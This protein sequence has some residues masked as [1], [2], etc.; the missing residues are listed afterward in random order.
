[1]DVI[2][3]KL[4][5]L[6]MS[7]LDYYLNITKIENVVG[8]WQSMTAAANVIPGIDKLG[9]F[10]LWFLNNSYTRSDNV[11]NWIKGQ[12][13]YQ[14]Y[15]AEVVSPC[16]VGKVYGIIVIKTLLKCFQKLRI[17]T[18]L[19]VW[20][21]LDIEIDLSFLEKLV[22]YIINYVCQT[23]I[24]HPAEA[25]ESFIR[26]T[27]TRE[28]YECWMKNHGCNPDIYE[29]VLQSRREQPTPHEYQFWC[30]RNNI[31]LDQENILLRQR[32]FTDGMERKMLQD[33]YWELPTIND[34]L[35]W[36]Q[37][38][39]FDTKYVEDFQLMEGFDAKFWPKFGPD[40]TALGMKE[41]YAR[42]HYAAHWINPSAGQ[43]FEMVQRLRP[44]RV[45][46]DVQFTTDDCL[47]IL[48]EQD[49]G[50]Y[51]RKRL[52]MIAY[53]TFG[54]RF[55]RQMY[56]TYELTDHEL[57]QRFQ[58]I[59][60]KPEDADILVASER[61]SRAWRRSTRTKGWSPTAI[62]W[63]VQRDL[64]TDG[65]AARLMSLLY[66]NEDEIHDLI[67]LAHL[68]GSQGIASKCRQKTLQEYEKQIEDSY[69]TGTVSR[70]DVI[71]SLTAMG[72][73]N[74][75]SQTRADTV[76]L[77]IETEFAKKHI[78]G[79]K[80]Q[81]MRGIIN[82]AGAMNALVGAGV[83]GQ[84]ANQ[85]IN[86]WGTEL[87]PERKTATA[88]K[89]ALWYQKG[90]IDQGTAYNRLRNLG[91]DDPD[92]VL[93]VA[94]ANRAIL[95]AEVKRIQ[96]ANRMIEQRRKELERLAKANEAQARRIQSEYR[97]MYPYTKLQAWLKEGIISEDVMRLRMRRGGYSLEA[98]NNY[99]AEVYAK[100]G[101]S[102]NGKVK[103]TS[104]G[105]VGS[106]PTS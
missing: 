70:D 82:I 81:Y 25:M 33:L 105:T 94:E 71:N 44:D 54:L 96:V 91:Y 97:T 30:R 4:N 41:E 72:Y 49:T 73:T 34:H 68:K 32:G 23:E 37:R 89:V 18:D 92:S 85:Y 28:Q 99:V 95:E 40:L 38:N 17:G 93:F 83:S 36:L 88:Q 45:S 79:I 12:T 106:S 22:D 14:R 80:K 31:P 26:D 59:G 5:L 90:L 98:I 39:V 53:K 77:K 67:Q 6:G 9:E 61:K 55:L 58:D 7:A 52:L 43:L 48:V 24:P 75:C 63:A 64:I 87:T 62:A 102:T 10:V 84:R 76:D 78:A 2:V 46:P 29:P 3:D 65:D 69:R 101:E 21:T 60:Y 8:L 11:V 50:I 51:F 42:L 27:I 103:E 35:H 20:L 19:I 13:G 100:M 16:G 86:A 66:F 104:E 15:I 74:E 1:M 57:G 47:R 56:D